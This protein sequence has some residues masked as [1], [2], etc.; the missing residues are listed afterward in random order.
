LLTLVHAKLAGSPQFLQSLNTDFFLT[1]AA[2]LTQKMRFLREVLLIK[3]V[4]KF[5]EI[6]K[7]Q[8]CE[9]LCHW[10]TLMKLRFWNREII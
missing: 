8:T 9:R 6:K 10:I 2:K 4:L 7:T 1:K 3:L 5:N